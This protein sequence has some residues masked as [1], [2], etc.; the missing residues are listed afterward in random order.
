MNRAIVGGL[1]I[2]TLVGGC[3]G[4]PTRTPTA[5]T[6]SA[7]ASLSAPP[8]PA[9]AADGTL[10]AGNP[11]PVIPL[12][13][14]AAPP[15]AN[16]IGDFFPIEWWPEALAPDPA[17]DW[18]ITHLE[19]V[20]LTWAR[21]GLDPVEACW[22]CDASVPEPEF[23][24]FQDRTIDILA[25]RG[26]TTVLI[27]REWDDGWTTRKPDYSKEADIQGFLEYVRRTIGRY[28]DRIDWYEILNEAV[29][30]VE[31]PD[32]LELVRRTVPVIR[33]LD[34]TAK[35]VIGGASAPFHE[36]DRDYLFGVVGSDVVGLVDAIGLHPFYGM[37]P[38]L[39]ETRDYYANYPA[40]LAEIRATAAANGFDGEIL[41]EEMVWRT[42]RNANQEPGVYSEVVAAKYYARAILMHLGMDVWAGIAGENYDEIPI[43]ARV[44]RN[45]AWLIDR[46]APVDLQVSIQ[47][48]AVEYASYAFA[49][50][51]GSHYLALWTDGAA[52]D[53]DPGVP[54]TVSVWGVQADSVEVLDTLRGVQQ[55][56][57]VAAAGEVITVEDLLVPDY[58]ILLRLR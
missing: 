10:Q 52:V 7:S 2:V 55:E 45:L 40:L 37:S 20:G 41:A 44:V 35:I 46:A 16:R 22:R 43:I 27:L 53:E 38:S 25:E 42:E 28:G 13:L 32:Y 6:P 23:D 29:I 19:Q 3:A 18:S 5:A 50:P 1:L 54:I 11:Q 51:D 48:P 57:M 24:P 26:I 17:D 34:P 9:P 31:P 49:L 36:R 8:S 39:P 30:Y 58:P 33:E 12:E 56:L 15:T 21:I 47:G 4:P 14:A